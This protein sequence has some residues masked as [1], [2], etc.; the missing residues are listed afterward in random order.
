MKIWK[1]FAHHRRYATNSLAVLLFGIAAY[2]VHADEVNRSWPYWYEQTEDPGNLSW[3]SSQRWKLAAA[4]LFSPSTFK[5]LWPRYGYAYDQFASLCDSPGIER[6]D[7]G[8]GVLAAL[9]YTASDGPPAYI[10]LP[11]ADNTKPETVEW[12]I[13]AIA[14]GTIN[15]TASQALNAGGVQEGDGERNVVR[16]REICRILPPL[17]PNSTGDMV[18]ITQHPV[19]VPGFSATLRLSEVDAASQ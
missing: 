13:G 9:K 14:D 1:N 4:W 3:E 15:F 16:M 10:G 5:A 6:Y 7:I 11:L 12:F 8:S 19:P 17:E 18:V 2:G